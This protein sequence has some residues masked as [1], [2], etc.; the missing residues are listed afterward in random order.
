MRDINGRNNALSFVVEIETFKSLEE[1]IIPQLVS[2]DPRKNTLI[3]FGQAL[4]LQPL[5]QGTCG[6]VEQWL[7]KIKGQVTLFAFG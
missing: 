4:S 1:G 5:I 6:I 7:P 2:L 3:L